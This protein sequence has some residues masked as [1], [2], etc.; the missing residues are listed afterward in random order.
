MEKKKNLGIELKRLISQKPLENTEYYQFSIYSEENS[1]FSYTFMTNWCGND[2][3]NPLIE[4]REPSLIIPDI[5]IQLFKDIKEPL[6][7]INNKHDFGYFMHLFGG[8]GLIT[9]GLCEL[10]LPE[11]IKPKKNIKTYYGGYH[12]IESIPKTKFNRAATPKLRMRILKRDNLRC[13]ICGASPQ[14][15]EHVELH[16]HHITPHSQGGLTEEKNLITLC[17]TCHKGLE[18]HLDYSLYSLINIGMLSDYTHRDEYIERIKNNVK[19]GI[20]RITKR[21]NLPPLARA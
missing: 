10:Y 9:K 5:A 12:N 19:L 7:V 8:N 18:P 17:H 4:I 15:N 20:E 14:N 3:N 2:E 11:L 21:K 1:K 16:L 6:L 13:K